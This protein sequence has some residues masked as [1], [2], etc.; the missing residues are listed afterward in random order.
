LSGHALLSCF[1]AKTKGRPPKSPQINGRWKPSGMLPK[2]AGPCSAV[3]L[4]FLFQVECYSTVLG[5]SQGGLIVFQRQRSTVCCILA[6]RVPALELKRICCNSATFEFPSTAN[7]DH[8]LPQQLSFTVSHGIRP[9]PSQLSFTVSHGIRPQSAW[10]SAPTDMETG[11]EKG[12]QGTDTHPS[13]EHEND[14]KRS[15][16]APL[17][18]DSKHGCPSRCSAPVRS[19][20][21]RRIR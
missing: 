16:P 14:K 15:V 4:L 1:G 13:Q 8:L 17:P 18:K 9:A 12:E 7:F 21:S 5:S 3:T 6:V 20:T 19:R 10:S 2:W 11:I